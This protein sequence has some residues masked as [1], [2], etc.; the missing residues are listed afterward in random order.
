MALLYTLHRTRLQRNQIIALFSL[1][2]FSILAHYIGLHTRS[3]NQNKILLAS[4]FFYSSIPTQSPVDALIY[5]DYE[6]V[7]EYDENENKNSDETQS[8]SPA[9]L[10]DFSPETIKFPSVSASGIPNSPYYFIK[11]INCPLYI[12]FHSWKGNLV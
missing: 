10:F 9:N 1:A 6:C 11:K 5:L 3:A 8:H 4:E 2:F 7:E 12:F